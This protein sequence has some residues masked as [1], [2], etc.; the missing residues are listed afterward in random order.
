MDRAQKPDTEAL[1]YI[2]EDLIEEQSAQDHK[3]L[4][5]K[6]PMAVNELPMITPKIC[7]QHSPVYVH[8]LKGTAMV[9]PNKRKFQRGAEGGEQRRD[10]V[11]LL[12]C[13]VRL[14]EPYDTDLV[15]TLH[16]PD[17]LTEEEDGA[18]G[19]VGESETYVKFLEHSEREFK[20]IVESFTIL[21]DQA[22]KDLLGM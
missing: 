19:K 12:M 1:T 4:E 16:V 11:T 10:F 14:G 2:F 8:L 21:N 6:A 18:G 15:L 9:A 17:K 22:I 13:L 20:Q 3:V 5:T 7:P